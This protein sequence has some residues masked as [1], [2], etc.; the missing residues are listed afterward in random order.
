M[1]ECELCGAK[2]AGD[3]TPISWV[4]SFDRKTTP[5]YFC[6]SCARDNLPSIE[7]RLERAYW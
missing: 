5:S 3:E 6:G 7:C 2:A 4:L 1:I